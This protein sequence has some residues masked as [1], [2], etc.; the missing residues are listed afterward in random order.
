[1]LDVSWMSVIRKLDARIEILNNPLIFGLPEL[2]VKL[3]DMELYSKSG[4]STGRVGNL[5][6]LNDE[7][8]YITDSQYR[9]IQN[10]II[11]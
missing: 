11:F 6:W 5:I 1:M 8:K 2:V 7:I 10:A 3:K 4:W 9:E